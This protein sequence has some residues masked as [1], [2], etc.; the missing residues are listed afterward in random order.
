MHMHLDSRATVFTIVILYFALIDAPTLDSLWYRITQPHLN[1]HKRLLPAN[2]D[3]NRHF[4]IIRR[5][6]D[7]FFARTIF[8]N[9]E[10]LQ[11]LTENL[12][13]LTQ[14]D[15]SLTLVQ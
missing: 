11:N 3:I 6:T 9:E 2:S 15:C 8:L 10:S 5:M 7:K 13:H 12:V 1:L 14:Q 4:G